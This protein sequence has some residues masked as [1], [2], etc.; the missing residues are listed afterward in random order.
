MSR[1]IWDAFPKSV[2]RAHL[3]WV[4]QAKTDTTRA[5]RIADVAEKASRGERANEW[6]PKS[7]RPAER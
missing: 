2:R 6:V 1:A 3:E 5:R 7:D 4:V